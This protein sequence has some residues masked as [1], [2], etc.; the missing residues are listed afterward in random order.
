M[1]VGVRALEICSQ[2]Y[3]VLYTNGLC[4]CSEVDNVTS[5]HTS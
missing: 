4:V 2:Q 1:C 5:R 3:L